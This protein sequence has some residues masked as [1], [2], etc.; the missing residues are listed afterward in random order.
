M[1]IGSFPGVKRPGPGADHPSPSSAEVENEKFI[2]SNFLL[3]TFGAGFFF[4]VLAH[5]V[6]KMLI[7]Q[8][9]NKVAL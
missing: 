8:Q 5:P 3:L 2:I 6:F 4:K 1:G 9:P 7:I